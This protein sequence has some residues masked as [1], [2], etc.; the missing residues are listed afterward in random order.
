MGVIL[1]SLG[2]TIGMVLLGGSVYADFESTL[3]DVSIIA[4]GSISPIRCPV[5][6]NDHE[7]GV[8][9]ATITNNTPEPRERLV[10]AHISKGHLILMREIEERLVLA[11]NETRILRWAV[12]SRDAAYGHLILVKVIALENGIQPSHKGSCG[13]I[14]LNLPDWITG[15]ALTYSLLAASLIFLLSGAGLWWVY[16]RSFTGRRLEATRA[17][18]ILAAVILSGLAFSFLG[19]WEF[20]AAAFYLAVLALGVITPHFLIYRQG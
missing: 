1:F 5:L 15:Q 9:A 10:R 7:T 8:I 18:F 6:L 14:V 17:F 2:V 16:G 3:F 13:V 12:T 19:F 11:P 20:A 4:D